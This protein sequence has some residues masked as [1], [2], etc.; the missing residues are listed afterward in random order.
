MNLFK[1]NYLKVNPEKVQSM[2]ISSHSC[3]ADG[4]MIP[5]GNTII[6]W[7]ERMRV[8]GITIDDKLNFFEHISHM[9]IKAGRQLN[10]LQRLKR[11]L[12]YKS[13]MANY[14]S[15]VMSNSNYCPVVWMFTS[16][17]SLEKNENIKKRALCFVLNYYQ[18]NYHDLLNKSEATGIKIMKLR[19]LAIEVYKCVNYFN[20]EYLKTKCSQW[21]IAHTT[22]VVPVF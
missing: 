5:D 16:K 15:F 8:L 14:N 22:Y 3:N 1:Q 18:S 10:V 11:V 19:L 20:P 6:S 2:L 9:C 4:L 7:M 21:R 13:R 17:K 12:D